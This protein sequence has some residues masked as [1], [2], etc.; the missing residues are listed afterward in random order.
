MSKHICYEQPLNERIRTFLRLE[1]LFLQARYWLDGD[2]IWHSRAVLDT[3]FDIQ[4]VF[5]RADLRSELIKELERHAANLGKLINNPNV[6]NAALNTVL[7][8]LDVLIDRLHSI[9]GQPGQKLRNNDFLSS[10]RQ[11]SSIAGGDCAFDLPAYHQWL[12]YPVAHRTA[13]LNQWMSEFDSIRDAVFMI[14]SLIRDSATASPH[15]AEAGFYQQSLDTNVA[16][17]LIR[18]MV[19]AEQV[20][21]AEISAGKHRFTLRF[22]QN[23]ALESRARQCEDDIHFHLACCVL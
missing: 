2:S 6:D 15:V 9:N 8:E 18:V 17:Q 7:D 22:M 16:Y 4:N 12:Q 19:P 10:I 14:L 5:G 20:C 11:R 21:F 23:D 1:H 3:L 13:N